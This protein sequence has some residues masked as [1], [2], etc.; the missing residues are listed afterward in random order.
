VFE[1]RLIHWRYAM[2]PR[3]HGESPERYPEA[4]GT[5]FVRRGRRFTPPGL[6]APRPHFRRPRRTEPRDGSAVQLG[7][8]VAELT[9]RQAV[10]WLM[11]LETMVSLYESTTEQQLESDSR[12]RLVRELRRIVRRH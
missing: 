10:V 2:H 11:N 3:E 8:V 9:P 7:D 5:G 12:E 1:R 4:S 6:Q